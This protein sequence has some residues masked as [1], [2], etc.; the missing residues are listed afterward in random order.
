M[1]LDLEVELTAG[2][3]IFG[4][5]FGFFIMLFFGRGAWFLIEIKVECFKTALF[6][7]L[8]VDERRGIIQ[9]Q[10]NPLVPDLAFS[11]LD[12]HPPIIKMP[13]KKTSALEKKFKRVRFSS[14]YR[15]GGV[16]A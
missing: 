13:G 5:L 8:G 6:P 3:D 10:A 9:S 12:F 2:A 11:K 15:I 4:E 14:L 16:L 1:E 7:G